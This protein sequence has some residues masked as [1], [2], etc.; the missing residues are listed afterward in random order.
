[1]RV[2]LQHLMAMSEQGKT[3][4]QVVRYSVGAHPG[5]VGSFMILGFAEPS[6]IDVVYMETI[7]GNISVDKPEEVQHYATAF[8][9]L[10]AVALSPDGTRAM[11]HAASEALT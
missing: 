9:H 11:L 5:T 2:Q 1:M 3:T 7:G 6:E 4:I 10:R 8:D